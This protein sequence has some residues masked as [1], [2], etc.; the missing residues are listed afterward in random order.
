MERQE[1]RS[2]RGPGL[3]VI[4]SPIS[5]RPG[6][7][8][9]ISFPLVCLPTAQSHYHFRKRD[10]NNMLQCRLSVPFPCSRRTLHDMSAKDAQV[11]K[12][13]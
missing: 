10:Y 11:K 3:K 13:R 7:E 1:R 9:T 8:V 2:S 4:S 5:A 6:C 12:P